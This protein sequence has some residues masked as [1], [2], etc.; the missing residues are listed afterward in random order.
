MRGV[1]QTQKETYQFIVDYV[2]EKGVA[3]TRR[4]I[5]ERFGISQH[6]VCCRVDGMIKKGLLVPGPRGT[7]RSLLPVEV[8]YGKQC[9]SCAHW[10]G[11]ARAQHGRCKRITASGDAPAQLQAQL[12]AAGSL[13]THAEFHCALYQRQ[14]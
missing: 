8:A 4:E 11:D 9:G 3:P 7:S 6:A 14:Q 12:Q 5:G 2:R 13:V 10:G 1:T